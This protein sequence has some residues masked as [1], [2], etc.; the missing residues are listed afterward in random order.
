MML[1]QTAVDME[2]SQNLLDGETIVYNSRCN[3]LFKGCCLVL[4]YTF[5]VGLG[6]Y[7]GFN[8]NSCDGS[9]GIF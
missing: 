9:N 6:F 3:S 7:I 4:S 1:R 8:A 2:N 5:L